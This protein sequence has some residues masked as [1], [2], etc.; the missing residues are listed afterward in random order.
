MLLGV[1]LLRRTSAAVGPDGLS[2]ALTL[3]V[4]AATDGSGIARDQRQPTC[5]EA[6]PR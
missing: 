4:C 3:D 5:A 6:A 2:H 1:R